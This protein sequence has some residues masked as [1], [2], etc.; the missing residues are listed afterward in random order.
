[1]WVHAQVHIQWELFLLWPS[2]CY[3]GTRV[4]CAEFSIMMS[5][6]LKLLMVLSTTSSHTFRVFGCKDTNSQGRGRAGSLSSQDDSW[7]PCK[8]AHSDH[9]CIPSFFRP[10]KVLLPFPP[11]HQVSAFCIFCSLYIYVTN[12]GH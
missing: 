3:Y 7:S 1:M 9:L 11:E 4:T 6:L 8:F 12:K 5:S 2:R 10:E